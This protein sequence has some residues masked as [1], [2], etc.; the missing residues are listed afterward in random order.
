MT[1]LGRRRSSDATRRGRVRE[2]LLLA[3]ERP[4]PQARW[5]R[6]PRGPKHAPQPGPASEQPQ[7]CCQRRCWRQ[8]AKRDVSIGAARSAQAHGLH[9]RE[10]Q[11]AEP[12]LEAL[13]GTAEERWRLGP[14]SANSTRSRKQQVR[15]RIASCC[16]PWSR[17]LNPGLARPSLGGCRAAA[18]KSVSPTNLP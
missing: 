14:W 11:S 8:A 16:H 17:L 15:V 9:P 10:W 1:M 18:P 4:A 7:A 6:V 3:A 13:P 2:P 5:F 12:W